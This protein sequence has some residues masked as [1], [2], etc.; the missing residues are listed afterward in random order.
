MTPYRTAE[1]R[2][3]R[4]GDVPPA[5]RAWFDALGP[6]V[7]LESRA[8]RYLAP[9]DDA[10]GVKLREGHAEAKRRDGVLGPL[11]VGPAAAPVEGWTKWSFPL[12]DP[13][14]L[15]AEPDDAWVAVAKTRW[16]RHADACALELSQVDVGGDRWWSVCLEATG[17]DAPARRAALDAA[18]RRWLG[19]PGAPA[20]P[21]ADAAGYLAWL[22]AR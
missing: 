4:R 2:W 17:P 9:T 5:V 12:A 3:F 21:E 14:P 13:G 7:E 22:R 19:A 20:L 16:Q 15:A 8:D 1:A 6:D 10:L 11:R 18:A